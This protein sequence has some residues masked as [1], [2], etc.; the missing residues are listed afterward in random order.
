MIGVCVRKEDE[1]HVQFMAIRKANHFATIGASIKSC[2]GATPRVPGEVRVDGH[3][4]IVRVELRDALGFINFL[5]MPLAPGEFIKWSR[6]KT[7]N[8]CNA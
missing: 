6:S 7:K 8:T 5:G 3:V 4:V 2:G 1:L